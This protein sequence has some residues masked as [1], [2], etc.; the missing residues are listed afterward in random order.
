M[1]KKIFIALLSVLLLVGCTKKIKQDD[2]IERMYLD[3]QYYNKGNFIGVK[4]NDLLEKVDDTYILYTYNNYCSLPISCEEIF[5]D[6]AK[7]YRIDFL[8]IPFGEFKETEFYNTVK[9]APSVLI[10]KNNEIVAY[11]DAES[12]D[13]LNKYQDEKEFESWM[14][15]YIYFNKKEK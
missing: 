14:D 9:Y 10:I 1:Y 11:L 3:N 12:D 5:K 4:A 6:F 13:D 2:G 7:K 15:K 8:T